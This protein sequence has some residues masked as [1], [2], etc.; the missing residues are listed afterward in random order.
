ME[1]A[2]IGACVV[3]GVVIMVGGLVGGL[4]GACGDESRSV[5]APRRVVRSQAPRLPRTKDLPDD[6]G[7]DPGLKRDLDR[8]ARCFRRAVAVLQSEPAPGELGRFLRRGLASGRA[9]G[10]CAHVRF[11]KGLLGKVL[12]QARG[13]PVGF[14]RLVVGEDLYDGGRTVLHVRYRFRCPG[15]AAR[16]E[17]TI[18]RGLG[19]RP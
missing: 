13:C 1:R 5:R 2:W 15:R 16:A 8:V 14:G 9:R 19:K 10:A 7:A 17:V 12:V 6:D 18:E 4:V 11:G 3:C